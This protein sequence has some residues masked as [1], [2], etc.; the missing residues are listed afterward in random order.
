[1]Q[2]A[3]P[4]EDP[5]PPE[6]VSNATLMLRRKAAKRTLPF[7][8]AAGELHL[9]PSS[10]SSLQAEDIPATKKR[11]LEKPLPTTTDEATRKTA[12]PDLSVD[13]PPPPP[14][15]DDDDDLNADLET[16]TQPNAG[17]T[18]ATA[19]WTTDEDAKLTLAVANTSKKRHGKEYRTDWVVIAAL[20]PGRTR[21]QCLRR[22]DN[23]LNPSIA[24][25]AERTGKWTEGEDAKLQDAV[26]THGSKNWVAISALVPGR[27]KK[28]CWSRWHDALDPSI[29]RASGRTGKWAED[30]DSKLKD[31]VQIHGGKN[32]VAISALVPGRTNSQCH[33]RW[34]DVLDPSIDRT[35]GR[36][37]NWTEAEDAKLKDSVQTHGGKNWEAIATLVPGRTKQQCCHRWHKAVDPSTLNDAPA[38]G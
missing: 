3:P 26:Q 20:V 19:R 2:A 35:S 24:L 18:R 16:D 22:W 23:A 9:V 10:S 32:W 8:L 13:L 6:T 34:K 21:R 33:G 29:G 38:W 12:S 36:S 27:T 31:A 37:S 11:R 5:I 15:A 14:A 1:M 17:A 25:T 7:D 30:E 28:Q 4:P